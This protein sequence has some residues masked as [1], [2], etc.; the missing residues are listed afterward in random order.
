[1]RPKRR[2]GRYDP[3]NEMRRCV[4]EAARLMKLG[5]AP[6]NRSVSKGEHLSNARRHKARQVEQCGHPNLVARTMDERAAYLRVL[7]RTPYGL[8]S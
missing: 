7:E 3:R 1:M 6:K 5:R 4:K 8:A 2:S